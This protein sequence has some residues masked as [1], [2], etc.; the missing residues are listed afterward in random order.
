MCTCTL[1]NYY[2]NTLILDVTVYS[3]SF[4]FDFVIVIVDM[5][6]ILIIFQ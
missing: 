4:L 1:I 6:H 3:N 5:E 2:K